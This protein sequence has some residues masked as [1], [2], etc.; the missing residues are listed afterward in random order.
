MATTADSPFNFFGGNTN[1]EQ[2]PNV[3]FKAYLAGLPVVLKV[4]QK[5]IHLDSIVRG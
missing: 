3:F 4:P 2:E 1:I 5:K